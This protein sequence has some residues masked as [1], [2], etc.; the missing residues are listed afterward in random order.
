MRLQEAVWEGER[1]T[2]LVVKV[3]TMSFHGALAMG[4]CCVKHFAGI[5]LFNPT[6]AYK[7]SYYHQVSANEIKC[8]SE[9]SVPEV[10][11]LSKCQSQDLKPVLLTACQPT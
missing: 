8:Q 3:I 1:S 5:V 11:Q 4:G 9:K 10:T 2:G 6:I 7:C